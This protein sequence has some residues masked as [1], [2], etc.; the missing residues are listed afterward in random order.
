MEAFIIIIYQLWKKAILLVIFTHANWI[1]SNTWLWCIVC[2]TLFCTSASCLLFVQLSGF[3]PS[4]WTAFCASTS[5]LLFIQLSGFPP[6]VELLFHF[7]SFSAFCLHYFLVSTACLLFHSSLIVHQESPYL[8]C[9]TMLGCFLA[10][11]KH[12]YLLWR[13]RI[14]VLLV[15]S[16]VLI[17]RQLR[18]SLYSGAVIT[19]GL[20]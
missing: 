17:P 13:Y 18:F 9:L 12:T 15:Y 11:Q 4:P 6:S 2:I 1:R 7:G 3:P 5:C 8:T 14:C 19:E 20:M 16:P 10:L